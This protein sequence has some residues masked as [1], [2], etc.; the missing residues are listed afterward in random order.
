MLGRDVNRLKG[1]TGR[2]EDVHLGEEADEDVMVSL[3]ESI[4]EGREKLDS[5]DKE[6]LSR[7]VVK[8]DGIVEKDSEGKDLP[9]ISLTCGDSCE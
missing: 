8:V 1:E 9:S 6:L 2:L 5:D 7:E 4:V 3:I